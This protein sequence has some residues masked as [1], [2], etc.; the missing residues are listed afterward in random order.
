M[1]EMKQISKNCNINRYWDY[2]WTTSS[3]SLHMPSSGGDCVNPDCRDTTHLGK[4]FCWLLLR[5]QPQSWWDR[6]WWSRSLLLLL[7][8]WTILSLISMCCYTIDR[9]P[10][11]GNTNNQV[12]GSAVNL[13]RCYCCCYFVNWT[14]WTNALQFHFLMG[15]IVLVRYTFSSSG[16]PV[17]SSLVYALFVSFLFTFFLH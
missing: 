14:S 16:V 13:N 6:A 12:M 5:Q 3:S 1:I 7:S 4:W 2:L 10:V 17:I 11:H 9:Q 8:N 15:Y